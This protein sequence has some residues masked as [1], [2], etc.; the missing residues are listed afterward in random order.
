MSDDAKRQ[1]VLELFAQDVRVGLDGAVAEKR[2]EVVR[3]IEGLWDKYLM[4]L[5]QL[6]S[7]RQNIES[8]LDEYMLR[9]AYR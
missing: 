3:F 5:T 6:K 9:L 7:D 1:L 8:Q 2:Q 4:T